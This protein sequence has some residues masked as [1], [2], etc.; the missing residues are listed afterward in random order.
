MIIYFN[1][2][3]KYIIVKDDD[4]KV[5]CSPQDNDYNNSLLNHMHPRIIYPKQQLSWFQ[6][7]ICIIF[8]T[9]HTGHAH[10]YEN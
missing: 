1:Y 2:M 5:H 8:T 6:I 10:I 4:H 9:V 7:L 3:H